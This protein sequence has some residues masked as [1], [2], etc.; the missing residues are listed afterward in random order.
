ML[1]TLL[2]VLI[3]SACG[4]KKDVGEWYA[5]DS[6]LRVLSTT[7]MVADLVKGVGGERIVAATLIQGS[8]D[9]HS[10]QLVKGDDDK[11]R[12]AD[13]I[14]YNG[15]GLE[16]GP[17]LKTYLQS[18]KKAH[19]LGEA[20]FELHPDQI[21]SYQGQSD[22]HI[23]MD[24]ELFSEAIPSIVKAL[25]AAKP[26]FKAEFQERGE[27]FKKELIAAHEGIHALLQAIPQEKRYLVTS[28][29][30]FNYFARAYLKEP[31]E[32]DWQERFKAPEG[33]A[34]ESQISLADIRAILDHLKK[35]D[36][37]VIFPES[38]VSRDSIRKIVSAAQEEKR[39]VVIAAAS[40]FADAMGPKGSSG[41]TLIKMAEHNGK[42]I[43]TW[44][45]GESG[46]TGP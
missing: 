16:H 19:S 15:L 1:R 8:L 34:P 27:A 22:P 5:E 21:L 39:E 9:P 26:E 37:H 4:S 28:H 41:D 45:G 38:N 42:T 17:S 14:F 25:G 3:F 12:R 31:S 33:L 46:K 2:L 36:I 11:L 6:R 35:Y 10:Y 43:A 18:S 40:L 7:Q 20:I 30:A 13:L 24:L 29:D 32:T 23:W 44:I